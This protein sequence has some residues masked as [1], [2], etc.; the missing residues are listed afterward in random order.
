LSP[1]IQ[2]QPGL[3][4]ETLFQKRENKQQQQQQQQ[5]KTKPKAT[6]TLQAPVISQKY[7]CQH[8]S[9]LGKSISARICL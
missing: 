8:K 1:R 7:K 9:V 3:L 6:V 2:D 5:K 4:S